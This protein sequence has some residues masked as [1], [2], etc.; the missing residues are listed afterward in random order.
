[1]NAPTE[2]DNRFSALLRGYNSASRRLHRMPFLPRPN[3]KASSATRPTGCWL[4]LAWARTKIASGSHLRHADRWTNEDDEVITFLCVKR[5]GTS[6]RH[7]GRHFGGQGVKL[8]VRWH[9]SPIV[10]GASFRLRQMQVLYILFDNELLLLGQIDGARM[11]AIAG[12]SA[13][14]ARKTC[15]DGEAIMPKENMAAT[16][17]SPRISRH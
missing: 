12:L 8:N 5:V 15:S 6:L 17:R 10:S 16:M 9:G 14:C 2:L 11:G 7:L 4:G 1:M 3:L 13:S